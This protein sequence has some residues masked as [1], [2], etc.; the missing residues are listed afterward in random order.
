MPD[1]MSEARARTLD[2]GP[3][4]PVDARSRVLDAAERLFMERGYHAIAL[5]D[6]AALLGIRQASLY[7]HFPQGKEEI[8]VAVAERAFARHGAGVQAALAGAG[9]L[10]DQLRAVARWF[11]TQTRMCLMGMVHADLPALQQTHAQAVTQAA[12]KGLF[13]PLVLLFAAAQARGELR[14]SDPYLL[15][16]AFLALLDALTIGQAMAS[17]PARAALAD[18]LIDLMLNGARNPLWKGAQ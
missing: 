12:H 8:Y 11:A 18:Q 5:R 14:H 4:E 10:E 6:I 3:D 7:Y 9:S 1:V 15:A 13:E 16:G 17:T 2:V